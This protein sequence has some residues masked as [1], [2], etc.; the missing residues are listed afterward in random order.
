M[1][2]LDADTDNDFLQDSFIK[3]FQNLHKYQSSGSLGGWIRRVIVNSCIENIR[4]GRWSKIMTSF[5]D[6]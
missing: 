5:E 4:R 6:Q 1:Y 3:V 2:A